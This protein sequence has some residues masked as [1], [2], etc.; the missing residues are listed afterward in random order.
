MRT[1]KH[2]LLTDLFKAIDLMIISGSLVLT[3]PYVDTS[4]RTFMFLSITLMIGH[5]TLKNTGVYIQKR[6][7]SFELDIKSCFISTLSMLAFIILYIAIFKLSYLTVKAVAYF[8]V[9][10]FVLLLIN[11]ILSTLILKSLYRSGK[12]VR[13]VYIARTNHRAIALSEEL[14]KLGYKV[15]GFI[16]T[17]WRNGHSSI[18]LITDYIKAFRE[19]QIDEVIICLPLKTEYAFI[20]S[21]I[22]AAEEQGILI[23]LST[24]LFSL[25][26][27]R[28]KVEYIEGH[29]YL[30]LVTGNMYNQKVLLKSIIDFTLALIGLI[31][32]SPLFLVIAVLI[33]LT[34]KGP[35]FFTQDRVGLN[36]KIYKLYKFRTMVPN[37]EKRLKEIEHLNER[38]GEPAFKIRNDPRVTPVGKFLRKFSLDELPQLINVLKGDMSLVGPR[39]LPIRDYLLFEKD[40]HRRR[41]SVKP[42]ITCL[43]QTSGRNNIPFEKWMELDNYYIDNWSLWLDFKILL[44]TIPAVLFAKG[45]S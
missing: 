34:S 14:P 29:P 35:V 15:K 30:T 13:V 39:P 9:S 21:I 38:K 32:T 43:W 20:E 16:D 17:T 44:K 24:D 28:L 22:R 11:R 23:R 10:C 18:P 19:E 26:L 41:F 42:G 40:C 25:N 5:I 1:I 12:D 37:A 4:L 3:L 36:K 45:A 8:G 27:A 7:R 6:F 2:S 31:I 33:K